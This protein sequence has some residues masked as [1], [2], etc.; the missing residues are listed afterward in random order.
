[1]AAKD[2]PLPDAFPRPLLVQQGLGETEPVEVREGWEREAM[3]GGA[4][5]AES[6]QS[7]MD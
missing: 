7:L 6:S 2:I 1:M 5:Q 3:D 4:S